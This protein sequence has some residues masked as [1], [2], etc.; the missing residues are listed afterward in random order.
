MRKNTLM[1][2]AAVAALTAGSTVAFAQGAPEQRGG[3]GGPAGASQINPAS[4]NAPAEKMAPSGNSAAGEHKSI[5]G[6]EQKKNEPAN[7]MGQAGERNKSETTGQAPGENRSGQ[8]MERSKSKS[9][10]KSDTKSSTKS[11]TNGQ[12]QTQPGQ[13]AAPKS[14][15]LNNNAANPNEKNRA[16]TGQGAPENR[17]NENRANENRMEN[18]GA[19]EN[20]GGGMEN[21]GG[22]TGETRGGASASVNLSSEQRTRI[23]GIIVGERSAP[24]VD[25]VDFA[26]NVGTRVPR[27]VHLAPVPSGVVEI[28]PRW[29]GYEYFLVGDQL[30]VVDPHTLEIIAVLPA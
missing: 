14:D 3:A 24:R 6:A 21:R 27:T 10:T 29:R 18:R 26:V 19:T 16:T 7:R 2:A 9:D 5:Q 22:V 17:A 30:V 25:R 28:E 11:E 4:K 13:N 1:I 20:R 15:R 8:G 12:A 23:H